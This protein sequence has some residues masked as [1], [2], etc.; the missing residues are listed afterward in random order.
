MPVPVPPGALE[1]QPG[2]EDGPAQERWGGALGFC[3]RPCPGL[4]GA[5][6]R[7][8]RGPPAR[9]TAP[10]PVRP[11]PARYPG[12]RGAFGVESGLGAGLPPTP[13][14]PIRGHTRR[15]A[16][17]RRLGLQTASLGCLL[18]ASPQEF[19]EPLSPAPESSSPSPRALSTGLAGRREHLWGGLDAG[20]LHNLL[21]EL[22]AP[23][24]EAQLSPAAALTSASSLSSPQGEGT[25]RLHR[26]GELRPKGDETCPR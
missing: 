13:R 1:L 18:A 9:P 20:R 22:Q 26:G 25:A 16:S 17:A 5:A 21:S 24:E 15:T 14:R 10:A 12:Q 7:C 11:F 2:G 4:R 19:T 23:G 6:E 3:G 8:S